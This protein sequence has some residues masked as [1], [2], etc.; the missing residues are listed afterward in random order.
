M[1]ERLRIL[2]KALGLTLEKFGEKLGVKK[3]TVSQWENGKSITDQTITSICNVNWNGKYVN[4][5]WLRNGTGKMFK[6]LSNKALDQLKCDYGLTNK[7]YDFIA[8]FLS[9]KPEMRIMVADFITE[10]AEKLATSQRLNI[11]NNINFTTNS[12]INTKEIDTKSLAERVVAA[13]I[14]YE[15]SLGIVSKK[16]FAERVAVELEYIELRHCAEEKSVV[17]NTTMDTIE[18]NAKIYKISNQQQKPDKA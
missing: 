9:L 3:N 7:E 8:R 18:S 16:S 10:T 12:D 14:E 13:E 11:N 17:S 5:D 1:N 6:N 4:K 15:K 2:R